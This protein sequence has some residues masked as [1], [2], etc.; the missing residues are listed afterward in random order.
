MPL[1]IKFSFEHVQTKSIRILSGMNFI[2]RTNL[3]VNEETKIIKDR[4]P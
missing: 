3:L 4:G 2:E 1:P